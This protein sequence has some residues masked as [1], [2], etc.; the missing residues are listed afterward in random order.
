MRDMTEKQYLQALKN[1]GITREGFL[2]YCSCK[3]KTPVQI[4]ERNG[5]TKRR[6]RLAY[7]IQTFNRLSKT[8]PSRS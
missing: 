6:E 5:G 4:S 8:H 2:G 1:H 3:E 7:L